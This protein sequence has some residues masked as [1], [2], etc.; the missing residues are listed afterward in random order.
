MKDQVYIKLDGDEMNTDYG[1]QLT[2]IE[3][4]PLIIKF[5]I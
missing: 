5:P 2:F 3:K 1:P 4:L